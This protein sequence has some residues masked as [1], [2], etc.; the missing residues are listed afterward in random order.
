MILINLSQAKLGWAGRYTADQLSAKNRK[1]TGNQVG[2]KTPIVGEHRRETES[3]YVVIDQ[4]IRLLSDDYINCSDAFGD[5][6]TWCVVLYGD[7]FGNKGGN[8]I[9]YYIYAL[10]M[11]KIPNWVILC[12]NPDTII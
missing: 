10:I 11:L 5:I 3:D 4:V 7:W 12:L 2:N 1:L 9:G 8:T 6:F